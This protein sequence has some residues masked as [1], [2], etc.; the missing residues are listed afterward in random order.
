MG[1]SKR[2]VVTV[3]SI[4][5]LASAALAGCAA[6]PASSA[7]DSLLGT[8]SVTWEADE[9]YEALGG[10][11]NPEARSLADGNAGTIELKFDADGYDLRW[12]ELGD[13][14]PGTY[15][16]E[17]ERVVL[18]GT[19]DPSVWDCGD[20]VGQ[21]QA[22]AVWT[23]RGDTLA[24]TEWKLSPEPAIDWFNHALL[25]TKPLERAD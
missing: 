12:V 19:I 22:D 8:W 20:G 6:T 1:T 7:D 13:S 11:D 16:L 3:A 21:F 18:T 10:D 15:E 5:V 24:L 9:L 25:G 14:C 23:V 4:A 2:S 17:G